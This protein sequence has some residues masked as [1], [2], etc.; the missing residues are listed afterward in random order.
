[1]LP[2]AIETRRMLADLGAVSPQKDIHRSRGFLGHIPAYPA[3]TKPAVP[4]LPRSFSECRSSD[5][6]KNSPRYLR[7]PAEPV[8]F[9][10]SWKE[11]WLT[12]KTRERLP[13]TVMTAMQE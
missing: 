6:R 8:W 1:V 12:N 2:M 3:T 5:Q 4:P 10:V 11:T 9:P 7:S 13:M